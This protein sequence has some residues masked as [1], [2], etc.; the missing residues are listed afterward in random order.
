MLNYLAQVM[1]RN[2]RQVDFPGAKRLMLLNSRGYWLSSPR[3][4]QQW[5]FMFGGDDRFSTDNPAAWRAISRGPSGQ[6]LTA[7][8]LFTY[9]TLDPLAGLTGIHRVNGD[10]L[11]WTVLSQVSTETIAGDRRQQWAL[12]LKASLPLALVLL[13]ACIWL[14]RARVAQ[15]RAVRALR[16]SE[17]LTRSIVDVS[18]DAIVTMDASERFLDVNPAAEALF[19]YAAQE[20]IGQPA[21]VLIASEGEYLD[22]HDG[23][24]D[25]VRSGSHRGEA[26]HVE[27]EG[28]R[29]DG[30]CFPM[31]VAL[32]MGKSNGGCYDIAFI[33]DLSESKHREEMQRLANTVF[34]YSSEGIIITDDQNRIIRANP[35]FTRITGYRPEDVLGQNP[36][37][38]SSDCQDRGFYQTMWQSLNKKGRWRG[39]FWNKRKSGELFPE[40]ASMSVVKD[41]RGRASNYVAIFSDITVRKLNEE[42]IRRQALYDQRTDLP[43]RFLFYE[44]LERAS[45][46]ADRDGQRFGVFFLDLNG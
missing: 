19:G 5:S 22:R 11:L 27:R 46:E 2:F 39:V 12:N 4:E 29:S 34:E 43:N 28:C 14:A 45:L 42:K 30:S 44:R 8:G 26:G 36:R 9:R 20:L 17:S 6:I 23:F 10:V 1:L 16:R 40:E 3:A 25:Y 35:A 33:R 18:L 41:D 15:I 37:V 31:E 24:I 7:N 38:L 32:V 13:G 21:T